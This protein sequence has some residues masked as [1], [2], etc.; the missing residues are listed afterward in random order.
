MLLASNTRL[1]KPI[2]GIKNKTNRTINLTTKICLKKIAGE[3]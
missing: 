1:Q 3:K 2:M